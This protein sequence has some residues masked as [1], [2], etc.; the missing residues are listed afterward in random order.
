MVPQ[1]ADVRIFNTLRQLALCSAQKVA[2][3]AAVFGVAL[4][5]SCESA[6]S[7]SLGDSS[8]AVIVSTDTADLAVVDPRLMRVS[9]RIA[10]LSGM[11]SR[12]AVAPDRATL[13]L[14]S[15]DDPTTE[16]VAID[17]RALRVQW[18]MPLATLE[19]HALHDTLP[20]SIGSAMAVSPDGARLFTQAADA[21]GEGLAVVDLQ[22]RTVVDFIPLG[23]VMDVA[24]EMPS[25]DLPNGAILVAAVRQTSSA[26]Y[27]GLFFVLDA[28]SL[29]VRDS[30]T[31]TSATDDPT[32]GMQ[33]VLGAP[34]GQHSYVVGFQ[35]YRYDLV[36]QRLTDSVATPS[37][38]R[39]AITA[40][41]STLYRSD[42]GDFD[43]PGTGEIFVY[44]A[45][46]SQRAPINVTQIA[47]SPS[48]GGAPLITGNVVPSADGKLLYVASGT[49]G[50]GG[51]GAFEPARLLVIDLQADVLAESILVA[52]SSPLVMFV[53]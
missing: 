4:S 30:V 28:G 32:G 8:T 17:T 6:T 3:A 7:P 29:V 23:T 41:G 44:G 27:T 45:D 19:Q 24:A 15:F 39:L 11:K 36:D 13:Y 22:S 14:L 46:L 9:G 12:G 2:L 10:P 34:D 51:F 20:V 40:D 48:A 37:N 50:A 18:R 5:T 42:A 21:N 43:S 38:G 26:V 1:A 47:A 35:Q 16:L 25:S 53:R 33:Q 52:G 49:P 31:I